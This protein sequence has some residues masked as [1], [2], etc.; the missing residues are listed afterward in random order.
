MATDG[1]V[2]LDSSS[3]GERFVVPIDLLLF[4]E[5]AESK[6]EALVMANIIPSC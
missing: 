5:D 1:V 6:Y 4:A 3:S 2:A